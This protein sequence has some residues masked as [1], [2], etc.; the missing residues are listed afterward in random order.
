MKVFLSTI[1]T[2]GYLEDAGFAS[3]LAGYVLYYIDI[4]NLIALGIFKRK[5]K[6]FPFKNSLL[7]STIE[8]IKLLEATSHAHCYNF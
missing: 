5:R 4:F 6:F 1:C 3:T 8:L 2:S 7:F